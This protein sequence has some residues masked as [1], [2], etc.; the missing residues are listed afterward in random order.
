MLCLIQTQC[1]VVRWVDLEVD[2]IR[3]GMSASEEKAGAAPIVEKMVETCLGWFN[4]VW[5]RPVEAPL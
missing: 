5:W 2:Y 4:H 3:V 1:R